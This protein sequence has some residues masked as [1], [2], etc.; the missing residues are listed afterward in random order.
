MYFLGFSDVSFTVEK[1]VVD[2]TRLV[3]AWFEVLAA[4]PLFIT[5][6]WEMVHLSSGWQW[7][8]GFCFVCF[9][10]HFPFFNSFQMFGGLWRFLK[11]SANCCYSLNVIAVQCSQ[12]VIVHLLAKL[13]FSSSGVKVLAPF[14]KQNVFL[15]LTFIL[16]VWLVCL[17]VCAWTNLESLE[18]RRVRSLGTGVDSW[19]HHEYWELNV[20]PQQELTHLSSWPISSPAKC[21]SSATHS[22]CTL[23]ISGP[24]VRWMLWVV[25]SALWPIL[26][27]VCDRGFYL[28]PVPYYRANIE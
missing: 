3:Q 28:I 2:E 16:Y 18:V 7:P 17:N 9:L 20:S 13:C 5:S 8:K 10:E 21:V 14:A 26:N 6:H 27:W 24:G 19:A 22:T 11:S 4:S 1:V 25:F 15:K 12:L 23:S